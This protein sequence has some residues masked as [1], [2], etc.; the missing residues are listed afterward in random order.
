MTSPSE[1][2]GRAAIETMP[3]VE[4]GRATYDRP[5]PP[6]PCEPGVFEALL[7]PNRSLPP[8]GFAVVMGVVVSVNLTLGTFFASIGAWPVLGF[9]GLDVFLVWLAFRISYRQGR[10]HERVRLTADE[11]R[12]SR[13]LPS[14]H[15]SRWRLQPYWTEVRIEARRAHDARVRLVSKGRSLILGHFLSPRERVAFGET[16]Q[17]ALRDALAGAANAPAIDTA[18]ARGVGA[19]EGPSGGGLA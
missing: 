14:G 4:V 3:P 6:S 8:A 12:I 15:E 9:C 5:P 2:R 10:L 16:L 13:V 19:G 1:P 7:F 18:D 11:L 17:Q